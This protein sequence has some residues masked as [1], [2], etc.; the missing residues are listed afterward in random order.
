[1]THT[2]QACP[3]PSEV[4]GREWRGRWQSETGERNKTA[5]PEL[6]LWR[7][8][9]RCEG[10][11]PAALLQMRRSARRVNQQGESWRNWTLALQMR[12]GIALFTETTW[13]NE[14]SLKGKCCAPS[15]HMKGKR[16]E[17][18]WVECAS[19]VSY[20]SYHCLS[21]VTLK[22]TV[23]QFKSC[24]IY[25]ELDSSLSSLRLLLLRNP[26]FLSLFA[27]SGTVVIL[28]ITGVD[29]GGCI[30]NTII[31]VKTTFIYRCSLIS[32]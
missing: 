5:T 9:K 2:D 32:N 27:L 7:A 30:T 21:C 15:V 8:A 13:I 10:T 24:L 3:K 31:L 14:E 16:R 4:S 18:S 11:S 22:K 29:P 28:I 25:I 1:M 19:T 26:S 12:A 6:P 20:S 17:K 23:W